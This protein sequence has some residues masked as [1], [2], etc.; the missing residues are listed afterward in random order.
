M[1]RFTLLLTLLA[2][3]PSDG[4]GPPISPDDTPT[5]AEACVDDRTFFRER[6]WPE[7]IG[8]TC[9][10]CHAA[11]GLARDSALVL[12][13]PARPD[14]LD[15]DLATLTDL[16][17]LERD[18]VSVLLLKPRGDEGHGGGAVLSTDSPAYHLLE[19][20]VARVK[21]PQ[22]CPAT[23]DAPDEAEGLAPLSPAQ[24]FRKATLMLAGRLPEQRELDALAVGGDAALDGLLDAVMKEEAFYARVME[25]FNDLLLTDRYLRG[26]DG[27]SMID[28]R[29]FPETYWFEDTPDDALSD[30]LYARTHEAL[31]RE[32]LQLIAHVLRQ[33]RPFTEILTADYTVV[34]AYSARTYGVA[35]GP[36]PDPADPAASTFVEAKIPGWPHAG[37]LS[38]PAFFNRHPTTDTNRNRHRAWIFYKTFLATDI[39]AFAERPIDPT[40]SSVHNPTLNDPQCSVCHATLDPVAG[41]F[42]DFDDE[43]RYAPPAD[44]WYADMR[45]PAWGDEGLPAAEAG[46]ALPWLTARAVDDPR[47][48]LATVQNMLALLTGRPLLTAGLAG[49][50][51]AL[52]EALRQQDAFVDRV[53][54]EFRAGGHEL[55]DV[56]RAV[57]RSPW[58]RADADAGASAGTLATAGLARWLTPEEL[59]RK[60]LATTGL[61]WSRSWTSSQDW[62]QSDYEMLYGGIDSFSI[63]SRLRSPNGV[64]TSIDARMATDMACRAVPQDLALPRE[65][66]RLLPHVEPTWTPTTP[67][68]FAVPEAEQ[69]VRQAIRELHAR[70]LG[71]EIEPGGPEEEATFALWT[72]AWQETQD[73]I[74]DGTLD[75]DL[76]YACQANEDPWTGADYPDARRVRHDDDGTIRAWM[77]VVAYLLTDAR[78]LS[79]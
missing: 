28:E 9:I 74:L 54:A 39:L 31:A 42:Q 65:Q 12:A 56:V 79:E 37:V 47:F 50:D 22:T 53:A 51:P 52:R 4:G 46:R 64:M 33:H 26:R 40:S 24:T 70:L 62:L 27:V 6:L 35:D 14:H 23:E 29:G 68:G 34:N 8:E 66:R 18:G 7:V 77:A 67:D 17:G 32:P 10:S 11:D 45:P 16:A 3:G 36:W 1:V 48:A 69:R 20:F 61:P 30:T 58:F 13:S 2:C 49:D 75:D 55:R 21:Q 25:L 78:F 44:G 71:E 63:V 57:V 59:S 5:E 60:I 43:G 41:L 19:A 15:V 72:G 38:T 73:A 76:P